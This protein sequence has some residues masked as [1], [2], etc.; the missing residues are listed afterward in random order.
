[1]D[2]D[3]IRALV[4]QLYR[5]VAELEAAA[6]GRSFTPDGHLLGSIGEVLA[7][8]RY[9]LELTTASTEEVDAIA[10]DGR[11]VE[12]KCTAGRVIALRACPP[13]LLVCSD[14]PGTAVPRRSTKAPASRCGQRMGSPASG[15]ASGRSASRSLRSCRRRC[16]WRTSFLRSDR[17]WEPSQELQRHR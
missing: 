16:R 1:M 7:A 15:T 12:I 11:A 5:L 3:R 8:A 4:P 9:G 14:G 13:H 17:P 10:P 2:A 6:P